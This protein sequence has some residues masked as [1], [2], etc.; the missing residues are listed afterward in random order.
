MQWFEKKRIDEGQDL[1]W[2]DKR[3]KTRTETRIALSR[4]LKRRSYHNS[5]KQNHTLI[6]QEMEKLRFAIG[7][8]HQQ[9]EKAKADLPNSYKNKIDEKNTIQA[10][11]LNPMRSQVEL[12]HKL[13]H[14]KIYE[15]EMTIFE[16]FPL[17][18]NTVNSENSDDDFFTQ[19]LWQTKQNSY[20]HAESGPNHRPKSEKQFEKQNENFSKSSAGVSQVNEPAPIPL[21]SFAYRYAAAQ[22]CKTSDFKIT[23]SPS[24]FSTNLKDYQEPQ[25]LLTK[26]LYT[27][28]GKPSETATV[29]N[30]NAQKNKAYEEKPKE[31]EHRIFYSLTES[32]SAAVSAFSATDTKTKKPAQENQNKIFTSRQELAQEAN[33]E[34]NSDAEPSFDQSDLS[35]HRVVINPQYASPLR[36]QPLPDSWQNCMQPAEQDSWSFDPERDPW[37]DNRPDLQ[38]LRSEEISENANS[39][40][41]A[42][43]PLASSALTLDKTKTDGNADSKT[44]FSSLSK[45]QSSDNIQTTILKEENEKFFDNFRDNLTD[46]SENFSFHELV[47]DEITQDNLQ[48]QNGK[49]DSHEPVEQENFDDNT[50]L[51]EKDMQANGQAQK[52]IG[53]QTFPLRETKEKKQEEGTLALITDNTTEDND[54]LEYHSQTE[55]KLTPLN[56]DKQN[57]EIAAPE[58][59]SFAEANSPAAPEEIIREQFLQEA[60]A[61]ENPQEEDDTEVL[62]DKEEKNTESTSEKNK[63]SKEEKTITPSLV[64]TFAKNKTN[65]NTNVSSVPDACERAS[66]TPQV[67]FNEQYFLKLNPFKKNHK[68]FVVNPAEIQAVILKLEETLNQFNIEGRVVGLQQG[69]IITRYE[70]KIPPGIKVNRL[71]SLTDELAMALEAMKV[72]IEAPIPGRSTAGIEIPN[73]ERQTVYLGDLVNDE[74]FQ[75]SSAHLPLPFGKDIAGNS[76]IE[77]LVNMPHLLIAGATGSGKSVAVN[78]FITSLILNRTPEQ[79]RFLLIDPKLVELSHY[80]EIPHLLHPVITD[81][82]KAILALNWAVE[83]MERRYEDLVDMR[84]RDIRSYNEKIMA[85]QTRVPLMPYIVVLID[86]LGDLMMVAGK[87]VESSI[88]RLTQKARAVGIHLILATQRPSVDVITALIKANCPARISLQVAQKTD[89]RTILDGNGAEQLLGKGDML[90]RHPSRGALQRIQCPYVED[91]EVEEVVR[92]AKELGNPHYIVLEDPK[93]AAAQG[94]P[95]DEALMDEAWQIITESQ[96]ASASYLQRR[97]RIGYNRAARIIEAFEAKGWIGPQSGSK[98][99]EILV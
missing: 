96:K 10:Q 70:I 81:H 13:P 48:P 14:L 38:V 15:K 56:C 42:L 57:A 7:L 19:K 34:H 51:M 60:A 85:A 55:E 45:P 95:E 90:F 78:A 91:G 77:D 3:V 5:K 44:A 25:N 18:K 50:F 28:Q 39:T 24:C 35:R 53:K 98:P 68:K 89:S 17:E 6:N 88:I 93:A 8:P 58:E 22:A 65:G 59:N 43:M 46:V 11:S 62:I 40:K 80:N 52:N 73:K 54:N 29:A 32:P 27:L 30:E 33:L 41:P 84:V 66:I 47:Q 99:R 4:L 20:D 64:K 1:P 82:Q 86:E 87:D 67:E 21:L 75:E 37:I 16:K 12:R 74:A 63:A 94:D 9:A 69:P 76:V 2:F 26:Y 79:V 49:Q 72:R 71:L 36:A 83:E 97:L 23:C 92:Q 61:G 31:E